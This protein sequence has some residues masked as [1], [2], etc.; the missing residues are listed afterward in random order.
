LKSEVV[1]QDLIADMRLGLGT[2]LYDGGLLGVYDRVDRM[3]E[4]VGQLLPEP[5][6]F[7][8]HEDIPSGPNPGSV[9]SPFVR[10]ITRGRS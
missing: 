8:N 6:R 3:D 7:D 9:L 10:P 4:D 1:R 5:L 2:R